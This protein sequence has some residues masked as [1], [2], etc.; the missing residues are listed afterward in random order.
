MESGVRSVHSDSKDTIYKS[1]SF[2]DLTEDIKTN[3]ELTTR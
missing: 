1:I 2:I 3:F